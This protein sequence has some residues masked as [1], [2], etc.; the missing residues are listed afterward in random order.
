MD[1]YMDT[2]WRLGIPLFYVESLFGLV[3]VLNSGKNCL[4]KMLGFRGDAVC[5][6][7]THVF[8]LAIT[9]SSIIQIEL[10]KFLGKLD[11]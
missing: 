4:E 9:W 2:C 8:V 11:F 3:V 7:P 5:F 10:F 1:M 6:F